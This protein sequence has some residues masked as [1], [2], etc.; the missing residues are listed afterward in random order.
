MPE[1]KLRTTISIAISIF[2]GL[3]FLF[4]GF[5]KLLT[6]NNFIALLNEQYRLGIL[7]LLAPI[8]VFL[9]IYIGL[10]LVFMRKTRHYAIAF[11]GLIISFTLFYTYGFIWHKISDCHCFGNISFMNSIPIYFY[12]R[13]L[14]LSFLAF[15][16]FKVPLSFRKLK[17]SKISTPI[18][19]IS[20]FLLG[21]NTDIKKTSGI[22]NQFW[23]NTSKSTNLNIII[24]SEI[25]KFIKP[26]NTDKIQV[27]FFMSE[28]CIYCLNSI[29]NLKSYKEKQIVDNITIVVVANHQSSFSL[30]S[31][32]FDIHGDNFEIKQIS[33]N[34]FK[35]ISSIYPTTL[36][37]QHNKVIIKQLGLLPSIPILLREH[38]NTLNIKGSTF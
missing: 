33:K 3:V 27:I 26:V 36:F 8:V 7:S 28:S 29:E 4:S 22:V 6:I 17:I 14:V 30:L 1:K 16:L 9:E 37:I 23:Y 19:I 12:I 38:S 21:L 13:N 20:T 25:H 5:T 34:E 15:Y 10:Q 31:K 11:L 32:Y 18:I 24:E 2:L 35:Q